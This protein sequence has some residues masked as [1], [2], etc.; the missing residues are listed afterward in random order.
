VR[1]EKSKPKESRTV[2]IADPRQSRTLSFGPGRFV[3][4][5]G[6]CAV[7]SKEQLLASAR[8]VAA[9]GADLLRGGAF[10]PRTRPDSFQGL[11]KAG[12][13]LLSL[14]SQETGLPIVTE[15]LDPRDVELVA[16]HAA[17][18]QVGAR[19]MQNFPLLREVGRSGLPVLLK[20]GHAA[21]L[22][23]LIA[24]SEYVIAE[25]N[26]RVILCERGVRGFEPSMRYTL[27]LAAVPMLRQLTGLPVV[28][29]PSH[30]TGR[31][32][33]VAPLVLASVGAGAD[34]VMVE[35]HA[36]PAHALCDGPQ[37]LVPAEFAALM[38]ELRRWVA[39]TGRQGR[40]SEGVAGALGGPSGAS[41]GGGKA[42]ALAGA[43]PNRESAAQARET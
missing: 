43:A 18:L 17:V 2:T 39:L 35:V 41:M 1:R 38:G 6:P 14:A 3:V 7:E 29:D 30:A 19:N 31:S 21:T 23:E 9:S 8:A 33:L 26:E 36:D 42:Q 5:A 24:A 10:K 20:R 16:R 25:G 12:L 11:G 13:E 15:V 34:G 27:D 40:F 22:D 28:V 37:A 4:I 32:E